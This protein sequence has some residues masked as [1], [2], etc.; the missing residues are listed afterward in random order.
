MTLSIFLERS[1]RFEERDCEPRAVTIRPFLRH[2][3]DH[4]SV[5]D[6]FEV[7]WDRQKS[8]CIRVARIEIRILLCVGWLRLCV[9]WL[10]VLI[11]ACSATTKTAAR[12]RA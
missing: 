3:V 2:F 12:D 4:K 10:R 8:K 1:V 11:S 7:S 9:G 6:N 5:R